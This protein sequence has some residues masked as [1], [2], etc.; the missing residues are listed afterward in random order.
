MFFLLPLLAVLS[1]ALGA[2]VLGRDAA[3]LGRDDDGSVSLT[4]GKT[5]DWKASNMCLCTL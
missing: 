3:V 5:E 4:Q 2:V 1:H